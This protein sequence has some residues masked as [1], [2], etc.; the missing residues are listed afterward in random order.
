[1][2]VTSACDVRDV[3]AYIS[4]RVYVSVCTWHVYGVA[5]D[6]GRGVSHPLELEYRAMKIDRH[7]LWKTHLS[8]LKEQGVLITAEPALHHLV[9]FEKSSF[10]CVAWADV[11]L[12]DSK[13]PQCSLLVK[14]RNYKPV[15]GPG[16]SSQ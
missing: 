13:H 9:R 2:T 11:E 8:P 16:S 4:L 3:R 10:C 7:E 15:P 6:A 5:P 1:M 12:V 14:C